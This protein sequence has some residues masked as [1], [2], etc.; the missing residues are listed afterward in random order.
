M[1]SE[2]A[3]FPKPHADEA[4]TVL[5]AALESPVGRPS[6]HGFRLRMMTKDDLPNV[7]VVDH[8]ATVHTAFHWGP[9]FDDLPA[10]ELRAMFR[11][12]EL[13][14][15]VAMRGRMVAGFL[16]AGPGKG[17][18]WKILRLAVDPEW[19][20][21]GLGTALVC[22]LV[23]EQGCGQLSALVHER[24]TGHLAFYHR[25]GFR[26]QRGLLHNHFADGDGIVMQWRPA[27]CEG[28]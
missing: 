24:C 15:L 20:R 21:N 7:A 11:D 2:A 3:R 22:E 27:E 13:R 28:T 12:D 18:G 8:L 9:K 19:H 26:A 23:R 4:R 10:A 5:D 17:L 14:P 25:L 1:K 6:I 16:F